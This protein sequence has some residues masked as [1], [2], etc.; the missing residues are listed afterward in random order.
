MPKFL[1]VYYSRTGHTA[2][3]ARALADR[4]GADLEPIREAR[5]RK[6]I[7]QYFRS[8]REALAGKRAEIE[9]ARHDP[10]AYD[11]VLLGSPV[12]AS[13]PSTPVSAYLAANREK[14]KAVAFFVTLGGSGAEKTM[15]RM[16]E[17]AGK[18]ALAKFSATERELKSGK[19]KRGLQRFIDAIEE[20]ATA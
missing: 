5:S 14:L 8:A 13:H 1:V 12:W 20:A 18:Q 19:W 11:I 17:A 16:E 10:A 4:L 3:V 7:W 6:G 9:P 2:Q 15:A